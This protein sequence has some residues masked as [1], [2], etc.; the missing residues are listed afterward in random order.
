MVTRA[1]LQNAVDSAFKKLDALSVTAV[2]TNKTVTTFDFSTG[3]VVATAATY[4]TKGFIETEKSIENV[5]LNCY[6]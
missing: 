4:T 2:F 5:Y 3:E 1:K 6:S